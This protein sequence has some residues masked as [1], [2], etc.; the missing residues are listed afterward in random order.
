[1]KKNVTS[2]LAIAASVCI[3]LFVSCKKDIPME[4]VPSQQSGAGSNSRPNLS[5]SQQ[6]ED[7]AASLSSFLSVKQNRAFV[8]TQMKTAS[9]M[10]TM[11]LSGILAAVEKQGYLKGDEKTYGLALKIRQTEASMKNAKVP[12]PR[13]DLVVPTG[14]NQ[15]LLE[16]SDIIYVAIAP[17]LED[18]KVKSIMAFENGKRLN[19]DL[20]ASQLP[21]VPT[22]VIGPAEKE[23]L[24]SDSTIQMVE[25]R[26]DNQ[27][28]ISAK[29]LPKSATTT[30]DLVGIPQILISNDHEPWYKGDPE[31]Y[32]HIRRWRISNGAFIDYSTD[33][34]GVNAEN[35]WYV[36][37]DPNSTYLR[38]NAGYD[39]SMEI[40]VYERD[41]WPDGDDVVGLFLPNWKT[42]SYAGYFTGTP[43]GTIRD[44]KILLDR[45]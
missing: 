23:I 26:T 19:H 34:P 33:L 28:S 16:Q 8:L 31:I 37:G 12:I 4:T 6:L 17:L 21:Q 45:D 32:V 40:V 30:D 29:D 5:I 24:T 18:D 36:L 20:S 13:L 43:L 25:S 22:V 14:S 15:T 41:S 35:H 42:L 3:L 39:K 1:M 11:E 9:K 2:K 44:A 38:L 10:K 27:S 7:V